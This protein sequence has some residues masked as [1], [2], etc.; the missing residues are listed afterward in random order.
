ME[1]DGCDILTLLPVRRITGTGTPSPTVPFLGALMFFSSSGQLRLVPPVG[2]AADR[3]ALEREYSR[4]LF[5]H[6]SGCSVV[7]WMTVDVEFA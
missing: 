5:A 3:S 4:G 6:T 2:D 1:G 7:G